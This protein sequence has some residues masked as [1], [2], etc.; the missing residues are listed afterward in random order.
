MRIRTILVLGGYGNGN[1]GDEAQCA[2]TLRV[3]AARYPR[4]QVRNLTPNPNFSF[5]EHPRFAHDYAPRVLL[6]NAG[7]RF[8]WYKLDSFFRKA[9]FLFASLMAL[10]NARFVKRGWPVWFIN[11][12]KAMFLQELS[13]SS[14][15]YFC[16]GGYLTGAT[17]SRLWEGM[18]LCRLCK[19]FGVPVVMSGQTVGV[20]GGRFDRWLARWG[21][22]DVK[23]IGLRDNEDS[24]RDLA[25]VGVSGER[26][27]CT[28]DDALFCEKAEA[29][30]VEGRYI[31][32]NFHFWGI[33]EGDGRQAVLARI[34]EAIGKARSALGVDKAVFVAMHETDMQSFEA[35]RGIYPSDNIEAFGG[36]GQFREIRRAIADA[37]MLLTMKHHPIIF[38]AGE[39]VPTVSLAY[40]PYYVH[41]NFGA[42]Q[43]YGVEACSTDLA[44]ADWPEQFDAA[45][46]KA[47]D[48][49]WFEKETKAHAEILAARKEAFMGKVDFLLG[50]KA[51]PNG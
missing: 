40:S 17:R 41:K 26:V 45:L 32:V 6:Y 8:N 14:M 2:E 39:G 50:G 9:G 3:L 20:W 51:V 35:Y 28:H 18:V 43:Q 33:A 38:A 11:A 47:S 22:R 16:G 12:R 46:R 23:L 1:A 34:H 25:E 29:R 27:M 13:Q 42:M 44:A 15:L 4:H 21:F 7:R 30:Q 31:A 19:A 24:A 49:G 48:R 10:L 36:V 5:G 37:E